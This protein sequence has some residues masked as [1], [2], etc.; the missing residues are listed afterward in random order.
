MNK[1]PIPIPVSAGEHIAKKYGYDQVVIIARRVGDGGLEHVT[2][3]GANAEHCKVAARMGNV[4]KY[5][6]MGW[7]R[8]EQE[9]VAHVPAP[10]PGSL[11]ELRIE[12]G[13][14]RHD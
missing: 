3:Y 10:E 1:P 12:R 14:S 8:W 13:G 6:I 7:E 11:D 4:I 5:G 2:T 9:N